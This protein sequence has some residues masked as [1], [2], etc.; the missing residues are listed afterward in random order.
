MVNS[1]AASTTSSGCQTTDDHRQACSRLGMRWL[2]AHNRPPGYRAHRTS[3]GST[4]H[5][6]DLVV[7]SEVPAVALPAGSWVDLRCRCP[8][9]SAADR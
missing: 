8:W 3:Y 7:V 6:G 4:K 1:A 5:V 2:Y 9:L